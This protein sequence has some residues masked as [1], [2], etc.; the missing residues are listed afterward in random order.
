MGGMPLG[1]GGDEDSQTVA[2][3]H[4]HHTCSSSLERHP[5]LRMHPCANPPNHAPAATRSGHRPDPRTSNTTHH[6]PR[7]PAGGG[8]HPQADR[9]LPWRCRARHAPGARRL[10]RV[11]PAGAGHPA[12]PCREPAR[13]APLWHADRRQAGREASHAGARVPQGRD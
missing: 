13:D 3:P 4:R 12:R 2:R 5:L 11:A 6:T 1:C 8:L 7:P 10:G 9:L